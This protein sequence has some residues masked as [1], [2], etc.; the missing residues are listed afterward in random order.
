MRADESW[1]RGTLN[2]YAGRL[3]SDIA[4]YEYVTLAKNTSVSREAMLLFVEP[5]RNVLQMTVNMCPAEY[6]YIC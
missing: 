5:H 6:A 3:G 2:F 1:T 4:H